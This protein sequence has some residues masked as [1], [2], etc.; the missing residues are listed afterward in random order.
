MDDGTFL[1]WNTNICGCRRKSFS[2]E[3]LA[4]IVIKMLKCL[5][6]TF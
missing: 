6:P 2:L 1:E 3:I 5:Q 4:E